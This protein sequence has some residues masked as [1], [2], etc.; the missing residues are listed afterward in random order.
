ME[1]RCYSLVRLKTAP[2][3]HNLCQNI[4]ICTLTSKFESLVT[5][6]M[7]LLRNSATSSG[8]RE[9]YACVN[10]ESVFWQYNSRD[11]S[12]CIIY[13]SALRNMNKILVMRAVS[14]FYH[15]A[16]VS[17]IDHDL[18][19]VLPWYLSSPWF[20]SLLEPVCSFLVTK[21]GVCLVW[22]YHLIGKDAGTV[23]LFRIMERCCVETLKI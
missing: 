5:Y 2:S 23:E 11:T 6:W 1:T 7:E 17:S 4:W 3:A 9:V 8:G 10:S 15:I 21:I 19:V 12:R 14:V 13:T 18:P 16:V 20:D 22:L